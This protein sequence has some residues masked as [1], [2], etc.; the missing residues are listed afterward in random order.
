MKKHI[1]VFQTGKHSFE[2]LIE[3]APIEPKSDIEMFKINF[4]EGL[5]RD[6][7]WK[8]ITK[9]ITIEHMISLFE[10]KYSN[11][12]KLIRVEDNWKVSTKKN[13]SISKELCDALWQVFEMEFLID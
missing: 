9:K 7:W 1:D 12:F 6:Y 5:N 2:E 3:I 10:E 11:D 4:K 8:L 13:V